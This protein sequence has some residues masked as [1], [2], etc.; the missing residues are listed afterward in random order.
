MKRRNISIVASAAFVVW[1]SCAALADTIPKSFP[2][3]PRLDPAEEAWQRAK[4]T[5]DLAPVKA[6][7]RSV[8]TDQDI[9]VRIEGLNWISSHEADMTE[10]QRFELFEYFIEL[11]PNDQDSASLRSVMARARFESWPLERRREAYWEAV[12]QGTVVVE[13]HYALDKTAAIA[14]AAH[15]GLAEFA[16]LIE[17][18]AEL[19]DARFPLAREFRYSK[20]LEWV[21]ALQGGS[22]KRTDRL[23]LMASRVGEFAPEKVVDLMEHDAAFHRVVQDAFREACREWTSA[24]CQQFARVALAQRDHRLAVIERAAGTAESQGPNPAPDWLAELWELTSLARQK[25]AKSKEDAQRGD[26]MMR[27]QEMLP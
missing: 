8:F 6:E 20:Y 27:S 24:G 17:P 25:V 23:T 10:E 26:L 13:E 2:V 19:L 22:E 11:R 1:V 21:I 4:L 12:K 18:N 9:N 5:G 16:P 7:L 15:D 3:G 14:A